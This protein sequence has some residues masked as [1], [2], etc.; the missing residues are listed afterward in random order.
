M[1][2]AVQGARRA[3]RRNACGG[4]AFAAALVATLALAPWA[5]ATAPSNDSM[6]SP[7]NVDLSGGEVSQSTAEATAEAN[8]P[9]TEFGA[10]VCDSRKMVATAWFRILGNG[11]TVSIDTFTSNFDTVMAVYPAPT[12]TL[13]NAVTCNDDAAGHGQQSAVSF[14]SVAGKAYLVQVGGCKACGTFDAGDLKMHVS[15]TAPEAVPPAVPPP[16][17]PTPTPTTVVV[18]PPDTDGDG[19]PD[20][21]DLCPAVK[22]AVDANN[23][24]CQDAPKHILSSLGFALRGTAMTS[25]ELTLVPRG[26]RVA[27]SCSRCVRRRAGRTRAFKKYAFTAKKAGTQSLG[28]VNG[29]R[30]AR[31]KRLVI[32]VTSAGMYGRK[33]TVVGV[34]SRKA[35]YQ[36]TR[37]CLA[38]GSTTRQVPCASDK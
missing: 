38:V 33:I 24:G 28:G 4:L 32:V 3:G 1:D 30:L 2:R 8:E 11:G 15:A 18:A 26:A 20:S 37:R 27:V 10:G 6:A 35:G 13:E 22:P 31:G 16:P 19:I 34:P 23:D 7:F 21:K 29:L 25:V 14:P 5:V 9:L 12:P 36:R 17:P